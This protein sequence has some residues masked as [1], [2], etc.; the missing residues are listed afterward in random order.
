MSCFTSCKNI[1][2]EDEQNAKICSN[3]MLQLKGEYTLNQLKLDRPIM[4]V[5]PDI[6]ENYPTNI[7]NGVDAV[8][9]D[10]KAEK[11]TNVQYQIVFLEPKIKH[12]PDLI[13]EDEG[14]T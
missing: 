4:K 10:I 3:C 1:K 5:E 9:L 8:K 7:N 14:N 12:E 6:S 13:I 2:I 11:E